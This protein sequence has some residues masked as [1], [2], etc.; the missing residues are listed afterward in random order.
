MHVKGIAL[1]GSGNGD[2]VTQVTNGLVL[3]FE[4]E[5]LSGCI[6]IQGKF[7]ARHIFLGALG[8]PR[9]KLRPRCNCCS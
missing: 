4:D 6:V 8:E 3:R 1:N 2:A 5:H 9:R 7:C